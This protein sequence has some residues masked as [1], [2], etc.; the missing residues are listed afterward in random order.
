MPVIPTLFMHILPLYLM[1]TYPHYRGGGE[2]EGNTMYEEEEEEEEEIV[3]EK[4][5]DDNDDGWGG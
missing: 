3:G 1:Y 2:Y 4:D 5:I